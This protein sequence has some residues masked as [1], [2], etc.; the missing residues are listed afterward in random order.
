MRTVFL[1]ITLM[2]GL[3]ASA[4]VK[5]NGKIVNTYKIHTP[6]REAS[7]EANDCSVRAIASAFEISYQRALELTTQYG[8]EK[9]EGMDARLLV[10]M[11]INEL[12]KDAK[13]FGVDNIDSRRFSKK[14]ALKGSSYIVIS[15]KHVH[16]L[17]YNS[18]TGKLHLHGNPL[19]SNLNIIY[20][21]EL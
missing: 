13:H 8:R 3:I 9:G 4:Q 11:V 12:D 19:D 21:I 2:L 18:D 14:I 5:L 10:Q 15:K 7:G 16:T 6:D 20:A 1:I 17:K